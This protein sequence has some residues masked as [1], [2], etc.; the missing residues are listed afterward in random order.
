MRT[1]PWF[2][3]LLAGIAGCGL[4]QP[5]KVT[6]VTTTEATPPAEG[7]AAEPARLQVV[8]SSE[9]EKAIAAQKGKV[10]VVDIW[11]EY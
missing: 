1:L 6:S 4:S 8:K 5:P 7:K 10:V 3:L 9:V 2:G 11:A